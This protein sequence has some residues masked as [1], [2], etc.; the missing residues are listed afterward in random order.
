MLLM[1]AFESLVLIGAFELQTTCVE[2]VAEAALHA[3]ALDDE[4]YSFMLGRLSF[5]LSNSFACS[6]ENL[7]S[8][9][10]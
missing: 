1:A 3:L 9:I 8:Q 7:F 4:L 5:S 10:A 2:F 6:N